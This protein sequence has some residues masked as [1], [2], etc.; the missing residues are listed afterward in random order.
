MS[1]RQRMIWLAGDIL[2]EPSHI[3]AFFHSLDEQYQG[4]LPFIKEG[5]DQGEQAFHVIDPNMHTEHLSR[6]KAADTDVEAAKRR[7]QIEIRSWEEAYLR[8]YRFDLVEWLCL[9]EA[10]ITGRYL[11]G[12][13]PVRIV[14]DMGWALADI[15]GVDDLME[16][17]AR[18]NNL[19]AQIAHQQSIICTCDLTRFGAGLIIDTLRTHPR[20]RRSDSCAASAGGLDCL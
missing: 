10:V 11:Q 14:A 16:Y 12:P 2:K 5:I 4:V 7:G 13:L 18:L 6:L 19:E 1:E 9:P 20:G 17:E 3:C 8:G 15:P